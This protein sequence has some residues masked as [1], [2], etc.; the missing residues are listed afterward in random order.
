MVLWFVTVAS[1]YVQL[2]ADH[3]EDE[4]EGFMCSWWSCKLSSR[5]T[6]QFGTAGNIILRSWKLYNQ[7]VTT[8]EYESMKISPSCFKITPLFHG[9]MR[10]KMLFLFFG[11]GTISD[12]ATVNR[13]CEVWFRKD[14]SSTV[15]Y[16]FWILSSTWCQKRKVVELLLLQGSRKVVIL[17]WQ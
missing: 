2:Y 14:S 4:E 16:I 3:S 6:W 13:I 17:L 11:K 5:M 12:S 1:L 8:V 7:K 9:Y 10:Y 15:Q